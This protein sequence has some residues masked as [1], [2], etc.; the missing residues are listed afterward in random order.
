M[1]RTQTWPWQWDSLAL[2]GVDS[3]C[4]DLQQW[5][6]A[7]A[8]LLGIHRGMYDII[9]IMVNPLLAAGLSRV[10]ACPDPRG[11][12]LQGQRHNFVLIVLY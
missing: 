1:E 7:C 4:A 8:E 12:D 11:I 3:G 10:Y 5:V 2:A 6:K 9:T